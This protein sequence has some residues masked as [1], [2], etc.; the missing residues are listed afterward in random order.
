MDLQK[1]SITTSQYDM[2]TSCP[3]YVIFRFFHHVYIWCVFS[4]HFWAYKI[5]TKKY[6]PVIATLIAKAITLSPIVGVTVI[7]CHEF[8]S[9]YKSSEQAS[10]MPSLL[11]SRFL[12]NWEKEKKKISV[13]CQNIRSKH[14]YIESDWGENDNIILVRIGLCITK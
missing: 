6:V 4:I 5:H 3:I 13:D 2:H 14:T 8:S 10:T 9:G 1:T 7:K 12:E 11:Q